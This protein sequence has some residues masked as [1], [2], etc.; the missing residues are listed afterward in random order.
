M[1][2]SALLAGAA[3]ET[4]NPPSGLPLVGY[5]RDR[6]NTGV[7]LSLC[8]RALVFARPED[9]RPAAA[10]LV[11]D[12]LSTSAQTVALLRARAAAA[13][14]GLPPAA[15]MVA[16][17][18]TH[19]APTLDKFRKNDMDARPDAG[20]LEQVLQAAAAAVKQAWQARELV[21]LRVGH[22]EVRLGH[23]RRV[24][25]REG[26][27][28]NEWRDPDGLH[29][30]YFNPAARF[31]VF[32][33]AA[34]GRARFILHTYGCH[35]VTLGG[36][37]TQA[38]ADYPGYLVRALEARTGAAVAVHATGAAAD[39]NPRKGLLDE[40]SQAQALGETL[41]AAVVAALPA[42]QPVATGP[43]LV[44]G[45]PV[46][47]VLGPKARA[48]Y[49]A[50]AEE[51]A[52]GRTLASEMQALRLGDVALVSAPGE[53]FAATGTA[54]ENRS[55]FRHT[56]VIGYAN[57][58]LGYLCTEAA[59]REGGYEAQSPISEDME[60]PILEAAR[61]A[62]EAVHAAPRAVGR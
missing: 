25:D 51:S 8:L 10:L 55:P 20:Y 43:L 40:P 15:I 35:P 60:R 3:V 28:T 2:A 12:T 52:D 26:R 5:P 53:L 46:T 34:T 57:D 1:E 21:Q 9:D 42:A 44:H 16:A 56:F 7:S 49:S 30:G 24:V 22:A 23:N 39:I 45:E 61:K 13:L 41:A 11:L 6:P 19:S 38:N 59:A 29:H 54:I 48:N 31:L 62:L 32:E 27:A 17:T 37:N 33:A 18:H 50:R 36:G 47:F 58:S 14:P 4:I